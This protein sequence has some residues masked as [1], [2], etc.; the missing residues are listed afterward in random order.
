MDCIALGNLRRDGTGS[1]RDGFFGALLE[2]D[3]HAPL[4]FSAQMGPQK[5]G[6]SYSY[7]VQHGPCD[8]PCYNLIQHP[9]K[10]TDRYRQGYLGNIF[11]Y[12]SIFISRRTE[13]AH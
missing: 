8:L 3:A 1:R 9:E 6:K 10:Y 7:R 13:L 2:I 4:P 11:P 12:H 5:R